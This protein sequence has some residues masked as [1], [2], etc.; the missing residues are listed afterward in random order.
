MT[1]HACDSSLERH[2]QEG[3]HELVQLPSDFQTSL[4]YGKTYLK[5]K[6]ESCVRLIFTEFLISLTLIFLVK[7]SPF[8]HWKNGVELLTV[9]FEATFKILAPALPSEKMSVCSGFQWCEK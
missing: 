5:T 8:L 6:Q 3:G 4:D 1:V 2:R 7:C 9:D